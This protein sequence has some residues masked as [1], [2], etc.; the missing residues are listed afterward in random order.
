[1][2]TLGSIASASPEGEKSL[3]S[4]ATLTMSPSRT[5]ASSS[6]ARGG[7]RVALGGSGTTVIRPVASPVP[8]DTV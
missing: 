1:M 2:V 7:N 6:V 3:R 5:T 4:T 8:L